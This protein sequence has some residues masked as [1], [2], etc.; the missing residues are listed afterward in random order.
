MKTEIS[1]LR[2]DGHSSGFVCRKLN[3][4]VLPNFL[5]EASRSA[6]QEK[7]KHKIQNLIGNSEQQYKIVFLKAF[8]KKKKKQ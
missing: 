8:K 6:F 1:D 4:D 2:I 3:L 7:Y 5:Y